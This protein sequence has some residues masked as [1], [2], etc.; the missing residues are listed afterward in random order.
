ME[1][2]CLLET[3]PSI[4]LH[5]IQFQEQRQQAYWELEQWF[6]NQGAG[7]SQGTLSAGWEGNKALFFFIYFFKLSGYLEVRTLRHWLQWRGSV[8]KRFGNHCSSLRRS[9]RPALGTVACWSR[10]ASSQYLK[11]EHANRKEKKKK[12]TSE[13]RGGGSAFVWER[14]QPKRIVSRDLA[15]QMWSINE[16]LC[17]TDSNN[18]TDCKM[19]GDT[20]WF[21]S[22]GESREGVKSI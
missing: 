6:P 2:R 7:P 20:K 15:V 22:I 10:G 18:D 19:G 5:L 21:L 17:L 16:K 8:V 3:Q 13:F 14:I 4:I 11:R 9:G 1:L 12:Q